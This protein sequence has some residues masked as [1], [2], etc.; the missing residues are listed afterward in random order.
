MQGKKDHQEEL[1]TNFHQC[2]GCPFA[3][4]CIGISP[5]CRIT[6]TYYWEH[7]ERIK[8]KLAAPAGRRMKSHRQSVVEPVFGVL[9]QFMGI[10][11][12]YTKG[13][14]N[15]Y[16][17]MLMAAAAYKLKKL[18]KHAKPPIKSVANIKVLSQ[19]RQA[20][21]KMIRGQV[22]GRFKHPEILLT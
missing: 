6:I 3:K 19:S 14:R 13:I 4:S 22:L 18:L 2:K 7:D 1:I 12:L 10:R 20:L 5:E 9:T 15:A 17:Q 11:K 8:A 16:K 21:E